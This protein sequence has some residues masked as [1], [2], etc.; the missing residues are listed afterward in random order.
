MLSFLLLNLALSRASQGEQRP[1]L[2]GERGEGHDSGLEGDANH[3]IIPSVEG[4][5]IDKP[6][7]ADHPLDLSYSGNDEN[8][9][10]LAKSDNSIMKRL[11]GETHADQKDPEVFE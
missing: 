11:A 6:G 1:L 4:A 8:Q 7:E 10:L 9:P 5:Q 2:Q 3:G